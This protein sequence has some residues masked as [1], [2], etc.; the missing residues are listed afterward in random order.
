MKEELRMILE[1]PSRL[2]ALE[3][4]SQL[5][6]KLRYLD[7]EL[8]Y[9]LE[10]R[11][12]LRRAQQVLA[13][14]PVKDDQSWFV[15]LALLLSNLSPVRLENVLARLHLTAEARAAIIRGLA[16]NEELL[17]MGKNPKRS[18]IYKALHPNNEISLAIAASL[19]APGS[20][21]RR[22]VRLYFD[23][24]INVKTIF[25]GQDLL[26]MGFKEGRDLGHILQ[27]LLDARLDQIVNNRQEELAFIKEHSLTTL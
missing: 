14:Y 15:Y 22:A 18:E 3:I 20:P 12:L 27:S 7:E 11:K 1:L 4:L 13:R 21:V 23:E 24:L 9:G 2:T 16:I 5:G 10:Q 8:E 19:S 17:R 26:Q 6:A 25:T